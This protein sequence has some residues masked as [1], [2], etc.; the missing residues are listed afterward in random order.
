MARARTL[1][2][3][4]G[5]A[6][7]QTFWSRHGVGYLFVLP[8][9]AMYV[10]FK[11]YPFFASVY[12]SLTSWDGVS[13]AIE[14]VGL[15]NYAQLVYD[16]LV[17]LALSHNVIW[18]VVATVVPI[19]VALLLAALLWGRTPGFTLFRTAYFM[20]VL[21]STVIVAI[22][23]GWIYNP[24]FGILNRALESVGLSSLTRGWLGDPGLALFSVL[25]AAMWGDIGYYF[26]ILLAGLQNVD[27]DLLDAA[28]I[29]GANAWQRT[30]HVV[31]PQLANVLT[32]VT[33]LCLIHGLSAFE[34]VFVMTGG[35]P[36]NASEL[37]ATYTYYQA[38]EHNRVGY[39]AALSMLITVLSLVITITFI[40]LR[41]RGS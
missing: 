40:R 29:D 24:T 31:V 15:A 16:P 2:R 22:I 27:V 39:G 32:M 9:L 17:W 19:G 20:P 10:L 8:A 4:I 41:E 3:P 11:L 13:P 35:G 37:I 30:L 23:W 36:A 7:L 26:V 14:F 34:T 33:S 1:A 38:F 5:L 28:K 6:R 12:L 18:V 21:L 25:V